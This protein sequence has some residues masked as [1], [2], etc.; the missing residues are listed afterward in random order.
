[1]THEVSKISI[2]NYLNNN[3]IQKFLEKELKEKKT[4]FVSNLLALSENDKNIAECDPQKLVQCA[5]NATALNM[6]LNKNL[7]F[8]YIVAYKGVPSFQL[9]YKGVIQL[10]I[11]TGAYEFLNACEIRE[12]EISRN[13]ISGE[14]K[15]IGENPEG[16][17]V[18]YLAYLKLKSGFQSSFYMTTEQ[19]EKHALKY[20]TSYQYDVK[21]KKRASLW[22]D[23]E[24][25]EKMALKTVIKK[26]LGT[27]GIM[28]TDMIKAFDSDNDNEVVPEGKRRNISD[29]EVVQQEE[30]TQPKK[31]QI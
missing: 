21:N 2:G 22:S 16:K 3:S 15:F 29:A 23:P 30:P 26:L 19:I 31:V 13:K 8:A 4:E 25:R 5:M 6:P 9:G 20:S 24:S 17:V 28:T 12:G 18:G 14:I 7:G 1:M 27:Y 10:A 11:R